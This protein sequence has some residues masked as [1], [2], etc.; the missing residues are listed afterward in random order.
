MRKC[1][2]PTATDLLLSLLE[3]DPDLRLGAGEEDADEIKE[4]PF[5][6]QVDWDAVA[7]RTNKPYFVPKTKSDTDMKYIDKAFTEEEVID[8]PLE[9]NRMTIV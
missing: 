5:F 1:F 4:H 6:E 8:T 2:S 7:A 9:P 3:K